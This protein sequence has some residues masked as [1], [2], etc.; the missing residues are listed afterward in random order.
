EYHWFDGYVKVGAVPEELTV[1]GGDPDGGNAAGDVFEQIAGEAGFSVDA[2][3][4]A[5]MNLLGKGRIYRDD[6]ATTTREMLDLLARSFGCWWAIKPDGTIRVRQLD[7]PG[8]S[9]YT[10]EDH[11]IF[12]LELLSTGSGSN[13]VPIW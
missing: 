2:S 6:P 7:E 8:T 4:K 13:G 10:I 11:S 3:D 5:A 9:S 1:S 12:R